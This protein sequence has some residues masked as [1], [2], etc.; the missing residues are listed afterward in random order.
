MAPI[1]ALCKEYSSY[2]APPWAA[3][4]KATHKEQI[5]FC[6][7]STHRQIQHKKQK[8]T[9]VICKYPGIIE[10]LPDIL[11]T[12]HLA[13]EVQQ[14]LNSIKLYRKSPEN[15]WFSGIFTSD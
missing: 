2:P 12:L 15:Q 1:H 6:V 7:Y 14:A 10:Q 4:R 11:P 5:C 8:E 9:A 3:M 13:L